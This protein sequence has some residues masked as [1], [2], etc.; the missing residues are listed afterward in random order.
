MGGYRG[1]AAALLAAA[2]LAGCGQK[3][4]LYPPEAENADKSVA[5]PA[6]A[7]D[8]QGSAAEPGE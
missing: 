1:I 5:E 3:G 6:A 2:L 4:P 7:A 8:E